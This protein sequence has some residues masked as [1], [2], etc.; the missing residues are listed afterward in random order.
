MKAKIIIALILILFIFAGA[1]YT[2]FAGTLPPDRTQQVLDLLAVEC[3]N[4]T[5][6]SIMAQYGDTTRYDLVKKHIEITINNLSLLMNGY[7]NA[8]ISSLWKMYNLFGPDASSAQQASERCSAA[9]GDIYR[10]ISNDD[11]LNH[12]DHQIFTFD[13]CAKA[14]YRV[15][16]GTCFIG[17][18]SVYDEDGNLIGF[19]YSDCYDSRGY[20]AGTCWDCYYG[21][22]NDGCRKKP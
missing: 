3:Q 16:S 1:D 12:P 21:A 15:N 6:Y 10:K 7:D 13:D 4:I 19:Y 22:D 2:V 18:T 17:G 14:G 11:N 20:H 8:F 9:R 5:D